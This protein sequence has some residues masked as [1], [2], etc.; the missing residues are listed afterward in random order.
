VG[1]TCRSHATAFICCCQSCCSDST[2]GLSTPAAV[3]AALTV[4]NNKKQ[5]HCVLLQGWLSSSG[6][7]WLQDRL[8]L[9]APCVCCSSPAR[10]IETLAPF[11]C[12]L[13]TSG[14]LLVFTVGQRW[15]SCCKA[16]ASQGRGKQAQETEKLGLSNYSRRAR[17]QSWRSVQMQIVT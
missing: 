2:A 12:L 9:V 10:R 16:L 3:A 11:S 13:V 1:S 17:Q 15:C 5:H 4:P 8:C 7:C 6:C 14:L